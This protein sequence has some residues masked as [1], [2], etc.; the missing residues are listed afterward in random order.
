MWLSP[1]ANPARKLSWS[2][3]IVE[4]AA[5]DIEGRDLQVLVGVN[6]A[7]ANKLVAEAVT[8]GPDSRLWPVSIPCDRGPLRIPRIHGSTSC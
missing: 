2:L 8:G 1:A 6:T 4:A 3:E 7:L 5:R